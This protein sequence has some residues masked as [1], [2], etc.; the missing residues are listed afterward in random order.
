[1][2]RTFI[3]ADENLN[4]YGFWLPMSGADL[5]QFKRNPIM[6]WMHNRPFRGTRDEVLPIGTWENIR[7]E[8][9]QLLADAVFDQNDD[10][11]LQIESKVE[12]GI[13]RMASPG[14]HVIASSKDEKYLKP[15]QSRETP[16][17]W[18][19]REASIVDIGGSDHAMMLALYNEDDELINLSD[20]SQRWPLM[21]LSEQSS[22]N[23]KNQPMKK[24]ISFFKLAD[25]AQEDE[26]LLK[27]EEQAQELVKLQGEKTELETKVK[28]LEDARATEQKQHIANLLDA[29]V[30]DGRIDAG[31][32]EIWQ[33]LF[34]KD[35]DAARQ[36]VEKLPVRTSA[37]QMLDKSKEQ[38]LSDRVQFEKLSWDDLDKSG[39]LEQVKEKHYDLFEQKFE[40]KFGKKPAK[41]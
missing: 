37:S 31:S 12:A 21:E 2:A 35:F 41:I 38:N 4:N 39:K 34:D 19:V 7:I 32:R 17:K 30:K 3:L 6:L 5:K 28:T 20:N 26:I 36:A 14:I 16:T 27:A 25:T 29:A 15:G 8:N 23:N 18:R 13:I 9:G 33:N 40:G 24:L 11:A 10:F 22:I 1:M